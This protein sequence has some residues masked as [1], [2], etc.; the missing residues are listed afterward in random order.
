MKG[1]LFMKS[2]EIET[3]N[4]IRSIQLH[5]IFISNVDNLQINC[6]PD[7]V[8]KIANERFSVDC[9]TDFI[10]S[11]KELFKK[12]V[13]MQLLDEI[14]K[15]IYFTVEELKEIQTSEDPF[16]YDEIKDIMFQ[17]LDKKDY[18]DI[19]CDVVNYC[20]ELLN[21]TKNTLNTK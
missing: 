3:Y 18:E 13:L 4:Y 20:L 11:Y 6:S 19:N 17:E 14:L 15:P 2:K 12:E 16:T 7:N 21:N 9:L 8:K 5:K 10:E 1:V